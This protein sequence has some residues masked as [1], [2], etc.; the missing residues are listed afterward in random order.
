VE[1]RDR[2]TARMVLTARHPGFGFRERPFPRLIKYGE[3]KQDFPLPP[4]TS[5]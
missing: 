2:R 4:L 3:M 5:V 1:S